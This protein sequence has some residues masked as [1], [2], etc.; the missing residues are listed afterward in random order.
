MADK[1]RELGVLYPRFA[2]DEMDNLVGFLRSA[3]K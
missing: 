2:D 3:A 1:A